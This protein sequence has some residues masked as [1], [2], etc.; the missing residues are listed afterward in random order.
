MKALLTWF[1]IF[2]LAAG[3]LAQTADAPAKPKKR[4]HKVVVAPAPSAVTA[5]DLK[6]LRDAMAQ[7]QAQ[8]Q[9]LQSKM[10]ERDATL[11]QTQQQLQQ[12]Q[13]QLQDA[14][15]KATAAVTTA[16]QTSD[17][18]G[19]LQSDVADIRLNTTNLATSTQEDQKK[20]SALAT[21]MGRF[22]FTGDMRVRGESYDQN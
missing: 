9:E 14:Q 1:T 7:Q 21:A 2:A 19:K 10:A 4:V 3:G 22:R 17:S 13:G 16:S 15:S 6:A 11:Q 20:V 18:I 8:I 5:D 12:T